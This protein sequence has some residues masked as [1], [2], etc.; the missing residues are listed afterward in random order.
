MQVS[1]TL[2]GQ[3]DEQPVRLV[4]EAAGPLA[5]IVLKVS[6]AEG[7]RGDG[8]ATLTPFARHAFAEAQLALADVDPAAWIAG[9]PHARLTLHAQIK[10]DDRQEVALTGD[11]S[12]GNGMAGPLDR[13]RLPLESLSG[14]FDLGDDGIRIPDLR[15]PCRAGAAER[16]RHWRDDSLALD[17]EASALDAAQLASVLRST[18]LNGPIS[19]HYR[20]RR[21]SSCR[22]G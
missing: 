2:A 22:P 18:R 19:A 21:A 9:A 17:L 5:R 10:P 20:R 16:R 14:R 3:I 4:A 8:Q 15:P 11:F 12:V 7:L 13:Q 6:A 1:A